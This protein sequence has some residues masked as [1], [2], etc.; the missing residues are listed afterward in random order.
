MTTIQITRDL[1]A[2]EAN[3]FGQLLNMVRIGGTVQIR[4][5]NPQLLH[6]SPFRIEVKIREITG[7]NVRIER[8]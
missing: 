3:T 2:P 6:W 4:T 5:T 7:E 1:L 8:I